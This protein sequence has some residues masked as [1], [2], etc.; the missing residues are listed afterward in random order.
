MVGTSPLFCGSFIETATFAQSKDRLKQLLE[1]T[2]EDVDHRLEGLMWALH[3]DAALIAVQ[4]GTRNLW[5]AVTDHP[6]LRVY[7]RPRA[8]VPGECE[9]LWIEESD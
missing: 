4:I 3:R 5:V 7:L 6:Y 2:D 8:E 1:L 9:L